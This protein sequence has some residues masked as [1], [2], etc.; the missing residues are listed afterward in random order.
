MIKAMKYHTLS[1]A[2][3]ALLVFV[4][5]VTA[6]DAQA[7]R[8]TP[9]FP[10]AE[11]Y[12]MYTT[13]GRGG[14]VYHVTTLEDNVDAPV[15]GMF[16]YAVNQVGPR[17]I[18]FDVS[19]TIHLKGSLSVANDDITIAGQTAPGDGICVADWPFAI[20]AN[21]VV[22]RYIRVRLGNV[23]VSRTE[24]DGGHEGDGFGGN[25]Q[26]NIIIDHCSISWSIDE[27]LT[28]YGNRNTTVQWCMATNS[29][30]EAGH[31]KGAHGYGGMV[32]GGRTSYHHNLFAHHQ[33]RTPRFC[34]RDVCPTS[35]N[36]PTDYRNNV[37]YNWGKLGCY[38]AE[39]IDI[40]M[41][42]CYYKPGPTTIKNAL[43]Y[44]ERFV[45]PGP[46]TI[47]N[48]FWSHFHLSGNVNTVSSRATTDNYLY[49]LWAQIASTSWGYSVKT[50]DT[51]NLSAPM[52][53]AYVT[54]HSAEDA[55]AKV[56]DYAGCSLH[57][58]AY[59]TIMINDVRTGDASFTATMADG[60]T[61][62]GIIN[63]PNDVVYKDGT[64]GYPVLNSTVALKDSDS[65]GIPD[66]WEKANGLNPYGASDGNIVAAD[67]YTNLEHYLNTI[68]DGITKAQNAGG[69][70]MGE[71]L[72]RT[73]LLE[74]PTT[75]SALAIGVPSVDYLS[76]YKLPTKFADDLALMN[77]GTLLDVNGISTV[78][79]MRRGDYITFT[80]NNTY[81]QAYTVKFKAATNQ[82]DIIKVNIKIVDANDTYY[83]NKDVTITNNGAT[84]FNSYS[85]PTTSMPVGA[86]FMIVTMKNASGGK[87]GGN[88]EQFQMLG[89]KVTTGTDAPVLSAC[90]VNSN[91]GKLVL[92]TSEPQV[93]TIV[94]LA[95]RKVRSERLHSGENEIYG[96]NPGLYLIQMGNK[97]AKVI[98]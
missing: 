2:V 42:N 76:L 77:G 75:T 57:R 72:A 45:A 16:R 27:C 24:G 95:G 59:D 92:R 23:N 64:K 14:I 5:T 80:L 12:G 51:I 56:L 55:Y 86:Y 44:Q 88:L 78:N 4:A 36:N 91:R 53:Y 35:I 87:Y 67:G 98:F 8:L 65:D 48:N 50:K 25:G 39:G 7:T 38:G 19:G 46:A 96:L 29:L 31:S 10:G 47:P 15:K 21:N 9:A 52:P 41:V 74:T 43:G 61:Y 18:V 40:N 93:I 73:G 22:V 11:G 28:F 17:T 20:F 70:I 69:A 81:E 89:S 6:V 3:F 83:C 82:S 49:G 30:N 71:D 37:N 58:D 54:T 60:S 90:E 85:V 62:P 1:I 97:T 94:D 26:A 68:V 66:E 34:S 79:D 84:T 13:G 33:S 32:G 63:S